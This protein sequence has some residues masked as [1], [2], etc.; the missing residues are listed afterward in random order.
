ME[1]SDEALSVC[2]SAHSHVRFT[3]HTAHRLWQKQR[4]SS[5]GELPAAAYQHK[6]IETNPEAWFACCVG[7]PCVSLHLALSQL[8]A[9][10]QSAAAIGVCCCSFTFGKDSDVLQELC[11]STTTCPRGCAELRSLLLFRGVER[12][13]LK[14]RPTSAGCLH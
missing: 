1:Q 6:Q 5:S 2:I 7:N 3:T 11:A 9:Q 13:R 4:H 8:T 10:E 12:N 14:Q